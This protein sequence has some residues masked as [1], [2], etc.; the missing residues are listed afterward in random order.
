[1]CRSLAAG[2]RRCTT[3]HPAVRS[4]ARAAS[5]ELGRHVEAAGPGHP[6]AVA[7]SQAQTWA[8]RTKQAAEGGDEDR[9]REYAGYT[10]QSAEASRALLA[11]PG[12]AASRP[13]VDPRLA[14]ALG[15]ARAPD[16]EPPAGG[17]RPAELPEFPE[18]VRAA[19]ALAQASGAGTGAKFIPREDGGQSVAW[20]QS[21]Y[22][23][24]ATV[25]AGDDGEHPRA[26]LVFSSLDR[27][28]YEALAASPWPY[29]V[30]DDGS[31]VY[32]RVP[33]DQA[34]KILHA[35]RTGQAGK[36]WERHGLGGGQ[37][38]EMLATGRATALVPESKAWAAGLSPE[39]KRWV[40]NYTGDSY[41]QH[42]NQHL[43]SGRSLDE[44]LYIR[45]QVVAVRTM[46]GP[47]D[48]ALSKAGSSGELHTTYR[49]YTP[50]AEAREKDRVDAWV[51]STFQVGQDYRD[52]SYMSVSH[53][54][55]V[56]AGFSQRFWAN[57]RTGRDGNARHRVVFE[58]VSSRGAAVA[59]V[60]V[61]GNGERERLMPRGASYRVVGIQQDVKVDGHNCMVVQMVDTKDIPRH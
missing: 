28:R 49:G 13:P 29:R 37:D 25:Y 43:Q 3:S 18:H 35:A 6:A 48:S 40:A 33:V 19:S 56:A 55:A 53:C 7:Y 12:A 45:E 44:D 54:P 14:F 52:D 36:P 42:I 26:R 11:R 31:V 60:G 16:D 24:V 1:M 61:Q 38:R 20:G 57:P 30:E 59:A 46:T 21:G 10:R 34:E 15:P 50:P 47:I 5:A 39:E 41:Y 22:C 8:D 17:I 27:D 51:R 23:G 32:D 58:I 9:A 2:G 4:A